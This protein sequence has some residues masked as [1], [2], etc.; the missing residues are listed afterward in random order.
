MA[1][2]AAK[3][4]ALLAQHATHYSAT[5]EQIVCPTC[6]PLTPE[7][8]TTAAQAADAFYE[9]QAQQV[10][11]RYDRL[12][13]AAAGVVSAVTDRGMNPAYHERILAQARRDWPVLWH[14][15]DHLAH[16]VL[17]G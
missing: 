17:R 5:A 3:I 16:E 10:A 11:A 12:R 6:G 14:R 8:S 4:R 9:H 1:E 2:D 15:I 13:Q 7:F